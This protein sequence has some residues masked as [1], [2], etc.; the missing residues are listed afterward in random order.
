MLKTA[1]IVSDYRRSTNF[2]Y[3]SKNSYKVFRFEV[4]VVDVDGDST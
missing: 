4:K 2:D 1:K 3:S